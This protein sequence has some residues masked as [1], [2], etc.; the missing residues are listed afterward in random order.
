MSDYFN[1]LMGSP[2]PGPGAYPTSSP[3]LSDGKAHRL[4]AAWNPLQARGSWEHKCVHQL[5]EEQARRTPNATALSFKQQTLTY[6]ALDRKAD[7]IADRLRAVG[8]APG[9]LVALFLERSPDL[10]AAMLG[11]LK[12]GGAYVPLDP[13][14]PLRRLSYLMADANPLAV[15]TENALLERLPRHP[16]QPVLVDDD[17]PAAITH[18]FDGAGAP[19]P[20]DL[21]Y[22]IYTSG[23]TGLPKGVEVEHR[24]VV[25]MLAAMRAR[26]ELTPADIMPAITTLSFDIAVLEIFL[27]LAVGAR[28]VLAPAETSRDGKALAALL[29]TSGATILQAT[30]ATLRMLLDAGWRGGK[31]LKILCGGEAWTT[32][33]ASALLPRCQSLWNMYGPTETTVWSAATEI[34]AGQPV[35]IGPPIANTSFHVLDDNLRPVPGG[36][37]GELHIGGSGLARGYHGRPGLTAEKFLPDPFRDEDG[38]RLYK[39]GDL[40]RSRP[41]GSLEFLGRIDHQVKI[42]GCRIELG[43]IEAALAAIPGV[44]QA[45]VVAREDR[46]G[47]KRLIAYLVADAPRPTARLRKLLKESLPDYMLPAAFVALDRLPLTL[48]GKLD[49]NALP[50]PPSETTG[51]SPPLS[52]TEIALARIWQ[53]ILGIR[54][55]AVEDDFF[56]LGGH[57]LSGVRLIERINRSLGSTLAIADIF[58]YP[59]LKSLARAIDGQRTDIAVPDYPPGV[60]PVGV[61]VALGAG[62]PVFCFPGLGATAYAFHLLS[63]R[64]GADRPMLAIEMHRL[65]LDPHLLRSMEYTAEAVAGRIMSVQPEGPYALL[66]YSFGGQLAVEVARKLVGRGQTIESLIVLDAYPPGVEK[67]RRGLRR[68]AAHLRMMTRDGAPYISSR[69]RKRIYTPKSET[70]RRMMEAKKLCEEACGAYRPE[71]FPGALTLVHA[72]RHDEHI[73]VLNPDGGF[74]WVSVCAGG[75]EVIPMS[76]HHL[77]FFQEPYIGALAGHLGRLLSAPAG[78][79]SKANAAAAAS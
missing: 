47:E 60:T 33:L 55:V 44:R 59:T 24:A 45:V 2:V 36:M 56:E 21:A 57:S 35:V 71:S 34:K 12:A 68:I 3:L 72:T 40:A 50:A 9:V 7:A 54:R 42:R 70:E 51:F 31:L 18:G 26:L 41:D 32:E 28:I 49:R 37:P 52:A 6:R 5:F 20:G 75:V 1:N 77:E 62:R 73:E 61:P 15:L 79:C 39:T 38:A 76:C 17:T 27:P 63:E 65:E 67:R 29:E 58:Q 13:S 53:E 48:S 25:N 74:G 4:H 43:E 22:V 66:G 11:V 16:A 23:S 10:V 30:P 19:A 78:V 46:P 69:I 64:I 14:H 8:V